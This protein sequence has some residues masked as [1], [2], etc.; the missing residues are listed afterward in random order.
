MMRSHFKDFK[1]K[2]P[3]HR[4]EN[5]RES[6]SLSMSSQGYQRPD[7]VRRREPRKRNTEKLVGMG[8]LW[9]L[10][11]PR[12]PRIRLPLPFRCKAHGFSPG[13]ERPE[14]SQWAAGATLSPMTGPDPSPLRFQW[15]F[16]IFSR[17]TRYQILGTT[18][19][20]GFRFSQNLSSSLSANLSP[21][22]A[23]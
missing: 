6:W 1:T 14:P 12:D 23:T 16:L 7:N 4:R 19:S 20:P 2:Q 22:A 10:A 5:D 3:R 8:A 18:G 11:S 17:A 21:E 13:L 9:A 15:H